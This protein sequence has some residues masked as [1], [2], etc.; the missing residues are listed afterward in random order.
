MSKLNVRQLESFLEKQYLDKIT[1]DSGINQDIK[2]NLFLARSLS[3]YT[4][5]MLSNISIEK[6]VQTITDGYNDNGIDFIYI[7]DETKQ[8]IIGQSKWTHDGEKSPEHG[9]ILK[10]VS[11]INDLIECKFDKFND[12]IKEMKDIISETIL[13][14]DFHVL[15]VLAYTGKQPVSKEIISSLEDLKKEFNSIDEKF[16]YKILD[17]KQIY[18][19]IPHIGQ[20]KPIDVSIQI[21]DYGMLDNPFKAVYGIVSAEDISLWYEQYGDYL[22]ESNLRKFI[23]DSN[24]NEQVQSTLSNSPEKFWYFN[25]GITVVCNKIEK[26]AKGAAKRDTANIS[27]KGVKIVNGAQTVSNIYK[28]K[29]KGA[30]VESASVMIKIISL[31]DSDNEVFERD[32]TK[33]TNSQNRISSKDFVTLDTIHKRLS[34]ELQFY[35]IYYAY[36]TGDI[37]DSVDKGFNFETATVALACANDCLRYAMLSKTSIGKLWEDT[38]KPP[39]KLFYNS[40]TTGLRVLR[41]VRILQCV[42]TNLDKQFWYGMLPTHCNRFILHMVFRYLPVDDFDNPDLDIEIIESS[43]NSNFN[44]LFSE[45][46]KAMDALYPSAHVYHFFRNG[47]KCQQ[48][49]DQI[50]RDLVD[51]FNINSVQNNK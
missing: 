3:A 17:L 48:I 41:S 15:A 36:K 2:K 10:F 7:N 33:Y 38:S 51:P 27:I 37:I 39:Y 42:Q 29:Q 47:E 12:S 43:I 22:F 18:E 19:S 5:R 28:A 26:A 35:G 6:S 14:Y 24:I 13:D 49:K 32:I 21:N 31:E 16:N 23:N 45:M 8:L 9:D 50:L 20:G 34:K 46:K 11:G 40:K 1:T 25:N 30:N 4:V 44:K